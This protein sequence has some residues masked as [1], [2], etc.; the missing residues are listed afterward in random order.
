MAAVRP[1]QATYFTVSMSELPRSRFLGRI[2]GEPGSDPDDSAVVDFGDLIRKLILFD[3]VVIESHNLK[4]FAPLAQKFGYHGVKALLESGRVRFIKDLPLVAEFGQAPMPHRRN[5]LPPGTYSIYPVWAKPPREFLSKQ[6]HKVDAV[7]DLTAKQAQKVRQLA[8]ECLLP[9]D[10][11]MTQTAHEQTSRDFE[12]N[13][14]TLRTSI[15]LCLKRQFQLELDPAVIALRLEPLGH[16]EWRADT[17]LAD[18]TSLTAKQLHDVVG[19]GLSGAAGLNVRVA[20]MHRFSAL[21]SFQVNDLPLFEQKKCR[22]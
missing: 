14:L 2:A 4:E 22:L 7:P 17:N 13:P 15:A 3:E 9:S 12:T 5:F 18:L 6:L 11:A 19:Q 1:I 21:S 8:G 20:L 16:N 10:D